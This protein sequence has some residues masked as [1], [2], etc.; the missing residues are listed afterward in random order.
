MTE[1]EKISDPAARE[2]PPR[3]L[4]GLGA[5]TIVAGSMLGIGI[6]LSPP[7]VAKYVTSV[8]AY[9]GVWI[10]GGLAALGGAV[11]CAELG[12]LFPRN[13]GDFVFQKEAFGS[14]I[15]F[16]TGCVLFAAVFS[17]SIA[18]I[19]VSLF[20]YQVPTILGADLSTPLLCIGDWCVITKAQACTM[21]LVLLLSAIHSRGGR[22]AGLLQITTTLVPIAGLSLT[23]LWALLSSTPAAP[24]A[25]SRTGPELMTLSALVAA[26]LPVYFAYSGWNAVIY[27]SGEVRNP[28]KNIPRAL[29]IGTLAITALY[30]ILNLGYLRIL[31]LDG[32]RQ[33]G[34]AGSAAAAVIFGDRAEVA[35][36]IVVAVAMIASLNGAMWGGAR[37]AYAMA[38]EGVFLRSFARLSPKTGV[39]TRAI[40]YQ[41][42]WVGV[43]VFSESFEQ[44]LNLVSVSMVLAGSITVS[45]LFVLR[46]K[47]KDIPRTFR[48]FGY[49][50]LPLFYI[51]SNLAVLV[52]MLADFV[53]GE[54]ASLYPLLGLAVLAGTYVLHRFRFVRSEA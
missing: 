20:T 27:L 40:W 23:A 36:A 4:G 2:A 34:E 46:L 53:N 41:A 37:V 5:F 50:W 42:A 43:L 11:A 32:L 15:A 12:A 16:A 1:L 21:A 14:S 39:P 7:I 35:T 8:P 48:A 22:S 33:V 19:A 45:A 26:Y 49:P 47:R 51:L 31:G 9:I 13:G 18:A 38:S 29:I 6:F 54:Q 3:T 10:V 28:V 52:V 24:V 17:G 25:I 30:V 44:T